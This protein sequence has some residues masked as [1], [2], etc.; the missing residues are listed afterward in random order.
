[1]QFQLVY[2]PNMISTYVDAANK[3][4]VDQVEKAKTDSPYSQRDSLA[5]NIKK[6][7]QFVSK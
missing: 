7:T 5:Y 1:M 4:I 2:S 6:G 3:L